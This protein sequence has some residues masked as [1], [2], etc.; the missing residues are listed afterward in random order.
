MKLLIPNWFESQPPLIKP[1]LFCDIAPVKISWRSI[2]FNKCL[3]MTLRYHYKSSFF[4]VCSKNLFKVTYTFVVKF[5]SILYFSKLKIHAYLKKK[6]TIF[7]VFHNTYCPFSAKITKVSLS[8]QKLYDLIEIQTWSIT[9]QSQLHFTFK[10]ISKLRSKSTYIKSID[11][12]QILK[13]TMHVTS[14]DL[15]LHLCWMCLFFF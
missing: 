11:I 15:N 10:P 9:Y 8:W 4:C 14:G 7:R 5:P 12:I 13:S 1:S 3:Q 6:N 2:H